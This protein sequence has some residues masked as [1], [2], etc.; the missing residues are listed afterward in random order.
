MLPPRR[1]VDYLGGMS[2]YVHQQRV[3]P[4][5]PIAH[6]ADQASSERYAFA[7][8]SFNTGGGSGESI[9]RCVIRMP[10]KSFFGSEYAEVPKPPSHPNRPGTFHRFSR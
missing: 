10:T 6:A 1:E 9:I 3:R 7:Q 4:R 5:T 8:K 2:G